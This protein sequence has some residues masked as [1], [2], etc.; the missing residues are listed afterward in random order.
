MEGIF[1][2]SAF[3]IALIAYVVLLKTNYKKHSKDRSKFYL[4]ING[5]MLTGITVACLF[6]GKECFFT[7]LSK[8]Q[9]LSTSTL[10]LISW[11]IGGVVLIILSLFI[12]KVANKCNDK[13]NS[14]EN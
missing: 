5:S 8:T 7:S 11:C 3:I 6:I 9:L 2:T 4:S 14:M 13:T 12:R 10:E 1:W